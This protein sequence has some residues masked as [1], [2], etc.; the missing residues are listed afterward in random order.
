MFHKLS[1]KLNL[2]LVSVIILNYN[3]RTSLVKSMFRTCLISILESNYDNFE[4]LFVD[5]GSTDDSVGF[6]KKAFGDNKR[7]KI[8]E[9]SKNLG[10]AE[11]N[12]VALP[13]ARGKYVLFLNNDV[14][15]DRLFL[16]ELVKT[17]ESDS[18]VGACSC[19]ESRG[20]I[21]MCCDIY[22]FPITRFSTIEKIFYVPGWALLTK[23]DIVSR[24]GA[25]DPKYFAFAEDLDFCWRVRLAGYQVAVNPNAIAYHLGGGTL[26]AE[27]ITE[28]KPRMELH[29][30]VK[31]ISL[32]ERNMVR[33]LLKN[34]SMRNLLLILPRYF[35]LL[36]V[37]CF[38]FLFLGGVSVFLNI[39]VKAVYWNIKNFRNTW[40]MHEKIQQ[41]RKVDD[42][43]IQKSMLKG[44]ARIQYYKKLL[45]KGV[46]KLVYKK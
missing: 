38:V 20:S 12:N 6:V 17:M 7:L 11:G 9:N 18:D 22:G 34:Y 19:K 5:N 33:T 32:F 43:V 46:P 21:G 42:K 45:I 15:V 35:S 28:S 4:V 30:S 26:K 2:P 39:Y 40:F 13:Y 27:A 31:R 3:G 23:R 44:N 24:I 1:G 37:E 25:F 36:L 8:I 10:F 16:K 41:I 29:F 14:I